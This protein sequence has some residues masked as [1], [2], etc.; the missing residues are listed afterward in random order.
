MNYVWLDPLSR[1]YIGS[2][3]VQPVAELKLVIH[4]VQLRFE[5]SSPRWRIM[6]EKKMNKSFGRVFLTQ[7]QARERS[8][9]SCRSA[10]QST[11]CAQHARR[12]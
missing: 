7:L 12:E 1:G 4:G 11:A 8:R 10:E 6:G 2:V 9:R 3:M 5:K